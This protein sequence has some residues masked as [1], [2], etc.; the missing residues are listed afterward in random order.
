MMT[1]Y[2]INLYLTLDDEDYTNP[3]LERLIINR[4]EQKG[5]FVSVD[6]EVM[7]HTPAKAPEE[8]DEDYE[9]A[10]ARYDGNG[11]DWR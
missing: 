2:T 10:A 4:L 8:R 5:D 9:R 6:C 3:Q 11:K 1:N 7:E